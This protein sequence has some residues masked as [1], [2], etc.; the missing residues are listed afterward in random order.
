MSMSPAKRREGCYIDRLRSSSFRMQQ[1]NACGPVAEWAVASCWCL[2]FY[3]Y[4]R[5]VPQSATSYGR[6]AAAA[7]DHLGA[8]HLTCSELLNYLND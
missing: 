7:K 6:P 1:Y 4:Y 3:F 5:D 2:V 8:L